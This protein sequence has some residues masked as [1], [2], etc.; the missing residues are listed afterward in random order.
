MSPDAVGELI[1]LRERKKAKTRLAIQ[2]Q[3]L[4]LFRRQSYD[5]TTIE[6]IAAAAEISPSTFFRYFPTKEDVVMYDV[7][8]NDGL[9]D[10]LVRQPAE[11]TP[12][13]AL[14][15]TLKV[16]VAALPEA[17]MGEDLLAEREI[18]AR[19]IPQLRARVLDDFLRG[20]DLLAHGFAKRSGQR[21][22]DPAMRV[23]AGA[24]TGVL[25]ADWEGH[26]YRTIEEFLTALDGSL[27]LL[28]EGLS[29]PTARSRASMKRG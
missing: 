4:R 5:G 13:A 9:V 28:E 12:I 24:V 11:L 18:L 27:A 10:L 19:Q 7:L 21:A 16:V 14:R 15:E 6:Q 17:D 22:D 20:I 2:R 1:G 25:M 23:L 29:R 8:D 26:H 3:A